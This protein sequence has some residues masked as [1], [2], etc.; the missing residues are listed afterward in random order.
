M[1]TPQSA[2]MGGSSNM[3][4]TSKHHKQPTLMTIQTAD[5][6][7]AYGLGF[8]GSGNIHKTFSNATKNPLGGSIVLGL[9]GILE[10]GYSQADLY[11]TN[12]M[13]RNV[14]GHLKLQLI[15]EGPIAPAVSF[16]FG[17]TINT[18]HQDESSNDYKLDRN[19]SN[20]MASKN[21]KIGSYSIGL[22]LGAQYLQDEFVF[23]SEKEIDPTDINHL[24]FQGGITWQSKKDYAFITEFK[25][26]QLLNNENIG[27]NQLAQFSEAYEVNIGAR[28]FF[29]NW[30]SMDAGVRSLYNMETDDVDSEIHANLTGVV[31]LNSLYNRILNLA[32]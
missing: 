28:Y 29:R 22:H 21:L 6:L 30:I 19:I 3:M 16:Y 32:D 27:S 26:L 18:N 20:L 5:I 8:S 17:S 4:T 9:G 23:E 31:P 13:Q 10:L 25:Q 24:L 1:N 11:T 12:E 15:E 14:Q 7:E 2:T